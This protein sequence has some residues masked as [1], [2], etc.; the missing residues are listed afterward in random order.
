M[1]VLLQN[2]AEPGPH[3]EALDGGG[4]DSG[5]IGA[6]RGQQ[7][8]GEDGITS[9]EGRATDRC[10]VVREAD[11]SVSGVVTSSPFLLG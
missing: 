11:I 9:N 6:Q 10:S 3:R 2:T 7:L 4:A 1:E 5:G 8:A